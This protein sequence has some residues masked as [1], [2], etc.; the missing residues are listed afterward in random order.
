MNFS[1]TTEYSLRI[2]SYMAVEPEKRYSAE[3]L[4]DKL[5]IPYRYLRKHLTKLAK[6]GLLTGIKGK[7]GGYKIAKPPGE[8]TLFDIVKVTGKSQFRH[9][10]FFGFDN[11]VF[12]EKC[13][14]H[15]KWQDIQK[16]IDKLLK[17]TTL[18]ELKENGPERF[19]AQHN[20]MLTKNV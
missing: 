15:D 6:C 11:C 14:M 1:K 9:I 4:N 2:L 3:T 19:I 8:I 13:I 16:S 18:E 7:S 5:E 20:L 17:D 12:G 10:C